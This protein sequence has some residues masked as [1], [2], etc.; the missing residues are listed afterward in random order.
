MSD[1]EFLKSAIKEI[2]SEFAGLLKE[3]NKASE[4]RHSKTDSKLDQLIDTLTENTLELRETRKEQE[5]TAKRQER[6]EQNQ[7]E[8][9]E[10]IRH[11]SETVL[12]INERQSNGNSRLDTIY[13]Y[14]HKIAT[15]AILAY[16]GYT[17]GMKP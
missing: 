9:G 3:A 17:M 8:Q 6:I 5:Y 11:L 12:L 4:A 15:F 16:L 1:Q 10:E 2:S 14:A 13:D 7:K